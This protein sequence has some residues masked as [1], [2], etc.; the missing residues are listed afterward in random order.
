MKTTGTGTRATQTLF[1]VLPLVAVMASGLRGQAPS[2]ILESHEG[3]D[4]TR[5]E[6]LEPGSGKF[7]IV[8]EVTATSPGTL[9]YFNP[10]RKGSEA[11]EEAV[12][13]RMTGQRLKFDVVD[14]RTA[15]ASGLAHADAD[16]SY[17]R[18]T[19]PRP[20]PEG[21][22]IRLRI[23]KTYTDPKSYYRE[24]DVIVFDRSLG[25]RRNA[26]VM[27]AGYEIVSCNVP[28][29]VLRQPDGRLMVSFFH[30]GAGQTPLVV[31]AR[32]LP[33]DA[34]APPAT[35]SRPAK[36]RTANAAAAVPATPSMEERLSERAHQDRGIVYFLQ[37]PE[38]H[39]FSL[40]HD[41]TE[42]REGIDKYLNVVRIGSRA[43]SPSARLLDTGEVL[44]VETL[45]GPQ[46]TAAGLDTGEPVTPATEVV[47]IR[48]PA[49]TKG[50]S[51]RLRIIETYTDEGR[52]Y[53]EGDELVF[54]RSFGRPQ[55]AVV[56]PSGWYLTASS[57]PVVVTMTTDG[58]VRLGYDNPR[59]D[60]VS[61]L[62]KAARRS[63]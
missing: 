49:V 2:P 44:K 50:Q 54:D 21:G 23:D 39:A 37:Q 6:L 9:A 1:A 60:E 26:V 42:T 52:Y 43:S 40:Y 16:T 57:I 47:V 61:V 45:K 32:A 24:G 8:Y 63:R 19:L 17:I 34:A 28:S 58:R 56:L 11:S 53:L 62:L 29:Q 15:R 14:G 13:D 41:Y 55:N 59:P 35:P 38:T 3:D 20:V 33:K 4:Y 30:A 51:V 27:P 48:F 7:R 12:F 10:I 5:Y 36:A 25:I 18:V 31:K 22:E 46:I